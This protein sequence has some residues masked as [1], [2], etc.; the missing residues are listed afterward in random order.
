MKKVGY[1]IGCFGFVAVGIFSLVLCVISLFAGSVDG[2]AVKERITVSSSAVTAEEGSAYV[3]QVR[4][5]LHN[6]SDREISV[7][8]VELQL[9]WGETSQTQTF[10]GFD[11]DARVT[12]DLFYEWT[13]PVPFDSVDAVELILDG[14]GHRLSNEESTLLKTDTF[15]FLIISLL[16]AL[17]AVFF[18]KKRYYVYEEEQMSS[19][20]DECLFSRLG[21]TKKRTES[22]RIFP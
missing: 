13:S 12:H 8:G 3:V 21:F 19:A 1:S 16:C 22:D 11:I 18:A 4:G 2:L 6:E 14:E 15:L 10:G 5:R 17:F 9:R 7:E 20:K